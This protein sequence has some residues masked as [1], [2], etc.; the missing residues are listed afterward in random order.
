MEDLTLPFWYGQEVILK[1][2]DID[3]TVVSL[4]LKAGGCMYEC[5]WF[6]ENKKQ[7]AFFQDFEMK[8][9]GDQEKKTIGFGGA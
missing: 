8:P 6:S 1:Y 9:K 2:G 3:A 5:C 4:T 7:S